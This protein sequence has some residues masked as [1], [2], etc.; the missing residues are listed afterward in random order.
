MSGGFKTDII[1]EGTCEENHLKIA[2][3]FINMETLIP[4]TDCYN[5]VTITNES[6]KTTQLILMDYD[7]YIKIFLQTCHLSRFYA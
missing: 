5:T 1:L 4:W 2:D 6:N 3:D 7:K